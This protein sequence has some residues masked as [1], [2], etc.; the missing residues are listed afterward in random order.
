MGTVRDRPGARP[1]A[2]PRTVLGHSGG[3]SGA[4][5]GTATTIHRPEAASRDRPGALFEP[6][7]GAY[8]G[9]V[10]AR[11]LC[12]TEGCCARRRQANDKG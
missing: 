12:E 11:E 5:Q 9:R 7:P 6:C 10:G 8:A 3:Q 2:R 4:R 1:G